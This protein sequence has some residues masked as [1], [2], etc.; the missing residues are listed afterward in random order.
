MNLIKAT[1]RFWWLALLAIVALGVRAAFA[2]HVEEG[3][4]VDATGTLQIVRASDAGPVLD[5]FA[6]EQMAEMPDP[7]W[8]PIGTQTPSGCFPYEGPLL[9]NRTIAQPCPVGYACAT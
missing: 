5:N 8:Y 3:A 2:D 1:R 9:Y 4:L 6:T 7:R